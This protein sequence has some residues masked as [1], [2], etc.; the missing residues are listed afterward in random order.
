MI[1]GFLVKVFRRRMLWLISGGENG[2]ERFESGFSSLVLDF[3]S[4]SC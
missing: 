3:L 2:V 4:L 1:L